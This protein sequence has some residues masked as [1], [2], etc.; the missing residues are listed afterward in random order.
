MKGYSCGQGPSGR[1][2]PARKRSAVGSAGPPG[3]IGKIGP[4]GPVG[5]KGSVGDRGEKVKREVLVV[6]APKG[7]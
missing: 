7:L 4:T 2:G 6:L 3:K 1:Q 5:G